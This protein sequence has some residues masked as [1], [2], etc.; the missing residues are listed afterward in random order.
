LLNIGKPTDRKHS[1]EH[2][3]NR[4]SDTGSLRPFETPFLFSPHTLFKAALH[5]RL[6]KSP[7]ARNEFPFPLHPKPA[8][9]TLVEVFREFFFFC[10]IKSMQKI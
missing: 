2:Q 7:D 1:C 4:C 6:A 8:F 3:Y 5:F 9:L 10:F